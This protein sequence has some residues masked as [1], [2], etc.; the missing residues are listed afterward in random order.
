M[1]RSRLIGLAGAVMAGA[2]FAVAMILVAIGLA[3]GALVST[4]AATTAGWMVPLTAGI[5]V[6]FAAWRLSRTRGPGV[7]SG[8]ELHEKKCSTC[9][10]VV[11]EEWRLCPHCGA[12]IE[13]CSLESV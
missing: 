13:S 5:T 6:A 2:G 8:V 3:G 10:G 11:F 12:M 1:T 4:T 9:G 7:S